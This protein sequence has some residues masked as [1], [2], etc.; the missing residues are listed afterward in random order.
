V[1]KPGSRTGRSARP[2]WPT[3]SDSLT[4]SSGRS[5]RHTQGSNPHGDRG[6]HASR[7][8][9]GSNHLA[10]YLVEDRALARGM[11]SGCVVPVAIA[12]DNASRSN[13]EN[14]QQANVF[15][16][17]SSLRQDAHSIKKLPPRRGIFLLSERLPG[18]FCY[19]YASASDF[20]LPGGLP[21]MLLAIAAASGSVSKL[22]LLS[23]PFSS[24]ISPLDVLLHIPSHLDQTAPN[25]LKEGDHLVDLGI[26]R[27]LEL[28]LTG[29]RGGRTRHT[30]YR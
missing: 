26:A 30:G 19:A 9:F 10:T 16:I 23:S 1:K 6:L 25:L 13:R 12:G 2:S 18:V 29:L 11:L 22:G 14:S 15:R 8:V 27:Q 7:A 17:A 20:P 5:F 21:R 3:L 24:S 28:R 4:R